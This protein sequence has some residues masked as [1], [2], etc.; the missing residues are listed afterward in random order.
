MLK[1]QKSWNTQNEQEGV[2]NRKEKKM[3]AHK[4]ENIPK[5]SRNV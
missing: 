2:K 3:N 1:I 5:L 4:G